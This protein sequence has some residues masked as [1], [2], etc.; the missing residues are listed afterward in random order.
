MESAVT[1]VQFV[2]FTDMIVDQ[3]DIREIPGSGQTNVFLAHFDLGLG[4]GDFGPA[5][6]GLLD[7][8][9]RALFDGPVGI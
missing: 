7:V 4:R 1:G 8:R 3:V 9:V 5:Q 6:I 2:A